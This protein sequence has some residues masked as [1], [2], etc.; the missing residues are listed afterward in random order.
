MRPDNNQTTNPA[1]QW[2]TIAAMFAIASIVIACSAESPVAEKPG[3]V[4]PEKKQSRQ[5]VVYTSLGAAQLGPVLDAYTA[6]TGVRVKTVSDEY[7]KLSARIENHGQDPVPDLLVLGSLAEL[8]D[9]AANDFLRPGFLDLGDEQFADEI[10]DPEGF[11]YPL[12]LRAR[13]VIYNH[14]LVSDDEIASIVDYGSLGDEKWRQRLCVSSSRIPGNRS[15]IAMLIGKL[16]VREAEMIVRGWRANLA[17]GFFTSDVDLLRAVNKGDCQLAIADTSVLSTFVTGG[18]DAPLKVRQFPL[19]NATQVDIS[20]AAVTRH[21]ENPQAA[22][23]LLAWMLQA[24]PNALYAAG[25]QEFPA[26]SLARTPA[27]IAQWASL[28]AEPGQLS[29]LMFLHEDAVL[30]AERARYP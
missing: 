7:R 19:S 4:R 27:A 10:L 17:D 14:T 16:G 28:V 5:I 6:E 24:K 15:L 23:S 25:G 2:L 11:W 8:A 9:A 13:V 30:L 21:A 3:E 1:R 26:N 20:G 18:R 22:A 12:G 29:N